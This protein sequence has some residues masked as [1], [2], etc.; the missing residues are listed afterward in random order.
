M[1]TE[2][3][4]R[5]SQYCAFDRVQYIENRPRSYLNPSVLDK[6]PSFTDFVSVGVYFTWY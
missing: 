6:F 4:F 1:E 2:K 5:R 3:S